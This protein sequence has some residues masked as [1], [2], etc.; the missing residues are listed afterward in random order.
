MPGFQYVLPRDQ[1]DG[2]HCWKGLCKDRCTLVNGHDLWI[3]NL[4]SIYPWVP[5]FTRL[6]NEH[7]FQVFGRA[8]LV[9]LS[10]FP[11]CSAGENQA[12]AWQCGVGGVCAHGQL[13][14]LTTRDLC[15]DVTQ[16][17]S[18]K[19]NFMASFYS[20]ETSKASFRISFVR[21]FWKHCLSHSLI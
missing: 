10:G 11:V 8:P 3:P 1:T 15:A 13:E 4:F 18:R 2:A 21:F 7:R 5:D 19:M 20:S 16:S 14:T 6:S 9:L 17:V 12:N